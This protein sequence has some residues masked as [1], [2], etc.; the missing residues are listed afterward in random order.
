MSLLPIFLKLRGRKCLVVGGG[1][2][3]ESKIESLLQSDAQVLVVAPEVNEKVSEWV[4][5]GRLTWWEK[6]FDPGD[7]DGAFLV[8]AA[9]NVP[10]VNRLVYRLAE[11]RS[12]LCNA[13]DDPQ[14][15]HFYYGAVVRRGPLQIAISTDG[16][17]PAL[18]QRL[19]RELEQQYGPE[20]ETWLGYLGAMRDLIRA[21]VADEQ[22]RKEQLHKLV[23]PAA[24]ADFV[25]SHDPV[26][27]EHIS[28]GGSR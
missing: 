27:R 17:S 28:A 24:F 7:L 15:C 26:A 5:A 21:S 2:V 8:I 4:R 18:A 25:N 19:R 13:V 11:E 20:Y 22:S 16:L 6:S 1:N 14:H 10:E 23:E 3:A 12:I 9:T